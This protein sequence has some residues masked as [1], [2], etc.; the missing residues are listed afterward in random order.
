M[1]RL[2]PVVLN[3]KKHIFRHEFD[4]NFSKLQFYE[5]ADKNLTYV[6]FVCHLTISPM[7]N[8]YSFAYDVFN[9][10]DGIRY[11]YVS[12]W[13]KTT[14]ILVVDFSVDIVVSKKYLQ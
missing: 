3:D 5:N 13:A 9:W 8:V 7:W 10:R 2:T 11:S 12:F 14:S 4:K 1:V 6:W